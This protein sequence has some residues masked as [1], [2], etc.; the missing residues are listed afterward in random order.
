MMKVI[1][2]FNL[3]KQHFVFHVVDSLIKNDPEEIMRIY[4]AISPDYTKK[5]RTENLRNYY[6][7]KSGIN[8]AEDILSKEQIEEIKKRYGVIYDYGLIDPRWNALYTKKT[9]NFN[10]EYIGSDLHYFY[11]ENKCIKGDYIK[12]FCDKNYI[13]LLFP[14]AKFP[15]VLLRKVNGTYLDKDFKF[16]GEA[17]ALDMVEKEKINGLFVKISTGSSGGKGVVYIDNKTKE[18][19]VKKI[20]EE[21]P[22]AVVQYAINQHSDMEAMNPTSVNTIRIMTMMIDGEIIPLSTCARIGASGNKVDNFSSGGFACGV[23]CDGSLTEYGYKSNGDRAKIHDNGYVFKEGKIP[24][25]D[26]ALKLS[27]DLHYRVPM[28]GII[29]WDF[30]IDRDGD[31]VF[32]EYNVGQGQID[33]HQY[34]NGAIYGEFFDRILDDTFRN[35]TTRGATSRFDYSV[36]ND[37]IRITGANARLRKLS[38]PPAIDGRKVVRIVDNAFSEPKNVRIIDIKEGTKSIGGKA[39]SGCKKLKKI[40]IPNSVREISDDAFYGT[41]NDLI[42]YCKKGSYADVFLERKGIR[43]KTK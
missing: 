17:K 12:G 9:G 18:D 8:K 4:R 28:F 27:M 36:S 35:F 15:K 31:I 30:A 38:I 19:E 11:V 42:I 24:Y 7:K 22:D 21:R 25:Y 37:T 2:I 5:K 6:F 40:Y 39:F 29:S 10:T 23:Q 34:N 26:K 3:M 14:E 13:E 1:G 20:F 43:H 32:I 33:L 41:N 16:I